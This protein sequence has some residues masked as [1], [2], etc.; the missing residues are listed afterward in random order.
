MLTKILNRLNKNKKIFYGRHSISRRDRRAVNRVLKSDFLTQGPLVFEFEKKFAKYVGAKYAVAV[1]NG[2]SALHLSALAM[3]VNKES[4]VI[5]T[6]ITFSASANCVRYCGGQVFLSDINDLTA[7]IDIEK[8]HNLLESS[9]KGFYNGIIPVDLAGYPVN[10]EELK[11]IADKFGL[12][13]IEDACHAP[14]AYFTDS[15]GVKQFCGNGKYADLTVFSFHP[16]K[17]IAVGEG[18]MITTNNKYLYERL[19]SLRS[20]GIVKDR[21][22]LNDFH[23]DWYYEMQELGHNYRI[24]DI[25]CALGVSQLDR[26][27]YGIKRRG[28]IANYYDKAFSNLKEIQIVSGQNKDLEN[29]G[30]GHAYHLY[31]IRVKERKALY[32]YLRQNN[33]FAQVHYIPLNLMPYYQK[34]GFKKGDFP[35]AEKYYEECLSLPMYPSLKKSE[36]KFVVDKIK[37]FFNNK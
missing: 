32:D 16:V 28:E 20:H 9:P 13:I 10:M 12:W 11:K 37:E 8:L 29:R 5:T 26:S 17:H 23:G 3:N 2:T 1:N 6:P 30:V 33:I 35:V 36:Q 34:L 31:I 14:G 27:E 19:L 21:E 24:P 4:R 7:T 15:S 18:G 25:L 22:K